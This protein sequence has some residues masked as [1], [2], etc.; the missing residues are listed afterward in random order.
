GRAA[1]VGLVNA[2]LRRGLREPWPQDERP[3]GRFSHP[4]WLVDALAQAW[5]GEHEAILQANNEPA[6]MWLCVNPRHAARE[7]YQA[8][9]Q[10]AEIAASAPEQPAQAL[11]LETPRAPDTLP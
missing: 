2:L 10:A 7:D 9:L 4:D 1:Q 3:G 5:P 11:R 8:Q 6:P